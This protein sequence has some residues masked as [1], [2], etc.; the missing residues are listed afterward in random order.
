MH[1]VAVA[2]R[3]T[4]TDVRAIQRLKHEYCFT[5]DG[6]RYEEW[7][8]LF[9]DDGRFV[10]DN[11]DSYEG[12]EELYAFASEEFDEAFVQSA[13]VVTNPL[14][15]VD[16]EEATGEW[17]LLLCYQTRE[18]ETGWTQAKY[19]DEYRKVDG[20]WRVAESRVTYGVRG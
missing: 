3:M 4:A 18:G 5:I 19:D 17:Y 13:H 20:E 10:R 11:G 15:E 12:H 2:S 1:P 14:V 9:T 16:G 6:G 7:A 8:S